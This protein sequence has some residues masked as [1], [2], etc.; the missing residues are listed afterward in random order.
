MPDLVT[1]TSIRDI[2]QMAVITVTTPTTVV[3]KE[4][5]EV[6]YEYLW[7]GSLG[8]GTSG[9]RSMGTEKQ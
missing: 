3:N 8:G 9:N 5:I 2:Q 1:I 6:W 7:K 4:R